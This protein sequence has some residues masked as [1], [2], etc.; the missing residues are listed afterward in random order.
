MRYNVSGGAAIAE[1]KTQSKPVTTLEE[2]ARVAV[3][4]AYE[5][6]KMGTSFLK[7]LKRLEERSVI[8]RGGGKTL[9]DGLEIIK[10]MKC[11]QGSIHPQVK[12]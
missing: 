8:V 5:E 10:G 11:D 4:P 6:I 9:N 2:I 3:I 12:M 7:Q 1:L